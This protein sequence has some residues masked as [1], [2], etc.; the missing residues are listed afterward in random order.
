[1]TANSARLRLVNNGRRVS[2][3][4]KTP[5]NI[6]SIKDR[7]KISVANNEF[8][9]IGYNAKKSTKESKSIR[10][11]LFCCMKIIC[12]IGGLCIFYSH[13]PELTVPVLP[14]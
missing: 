8:S 12:S 13:R 14:H 7:F 5:E 2:E 3:I 1:M 9:T 4:A 6:I 10:K 11:R